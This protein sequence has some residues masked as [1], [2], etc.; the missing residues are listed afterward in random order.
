MKRL[1]ALFVG[2]GS[3]M[4]VLET[5]RY[6]ETWRQLGEQLPRP[7]AILV[8]SAHWYTQG[9]WLTSAS[10]PRTIHDFRG[11]PQ[12]LQETEYPA[13]GSAAL[14]ERVKNLLNEENIGEDNGEW[15]L[16]HGS[17]G[18]LVKMFPDADIPVVQLSIDG[19][20]PAQWYYDTGRKLAALRDE[21]VLVLGSGNVVHNLREMDWQNAQA[22]PYPWAESF[23]TFVRDNLDSEIV[24]H[25]L[26]NALDREDGKRANPSPEHFLPLLYI[27]GMR[28]GA[29]PV[30][31]T[32]DGIES[33][34]LSMLSVQ[35]G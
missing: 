15:G 4:N 16:D 28:E 2:H 11:F 30:T 25:P 21:G 3:P 23:N 13:P 35:V 5:N 27:L 29:E 18:I 22:E 12:A 31:V 34:S 26:I 1:P 8:V 9:S 7:S 10:H 32:V 24:P 6:T 14:V 17:W 20:K 19:S 33:A